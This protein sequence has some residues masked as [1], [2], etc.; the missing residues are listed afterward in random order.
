MFGAVII[1]FLLLMN[2][3]LAILVDAY[4]KIKTVSDNADGVA[5]D[6][7]RQVRC[8]RAKQN[9]KRAMPLR[10]LTVRDP[11]AFCCRFR[12]PLGPCDGRIQCSQTRE[13]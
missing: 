5:V 1:S 8:S 3:L 12:R 2:M 4:I 11:C 13:W 7:Y 10:T 6:L 9:L